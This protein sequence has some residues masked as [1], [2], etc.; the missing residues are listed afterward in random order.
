MR[1]ASPRP[2]TTLP[3]SSDRPVGCAATARARRT[4]T[5]A[6][7]A[8]AQG[9]RRE[10]SARRPSAA[11]RRR[12]TASSTSA[13]SMSSRHMRASRHCRRW[14]HWHTD[15]RDTAMSSATSGPFRVGPG[16]ARR[17]RQA[18][19]RR[20]SDVR[21]TGV[22]GHHQPAPRGQRRNVRDA[23]LRRQDRRT[24]RLRDDL[25]GEGEFVGPPQHDRAKVVSRPQLTREAAKTLRRPP[26]VRPG[27]ARVE[28]R[29]RSAGAGDD[30]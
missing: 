24:V 17:C 15:A 26:L 30:R 9:A 23:R 7:P 5:R 4:R 27:R 22:A 6:G 29:E 21:R 16:R 19:C 18:A 14:W 12:S 1:S 3:A 2:A 25:V 20:G 13:T 11:A 8:G 28:Q 10:L